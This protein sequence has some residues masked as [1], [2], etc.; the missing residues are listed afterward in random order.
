MASINRILKMQV[1][2]LRLHADIRTCQYEAW[3]VPSM[4]FISP[5]LSPK[6][7]RTEAE[8]NLYILF[9]VFSKVTHL[10]APT[11]SRYWSFLINIKII[12]FLI[13]DII[14]SVYNASA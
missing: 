14:L 13:A 7:S 4:S 10:L 5:R 3:K 9:F 12:W 8:N 2:L 6:K 11:N 1:L